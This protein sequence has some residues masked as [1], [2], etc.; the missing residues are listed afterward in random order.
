MPVALQATL[1]EEPLMGNLHLLLPLRVHVIWT[2][3]A[4]GLHRVRPPRR[5]CTASPACG[6]ASASWRKGN[7]GELVKHQRH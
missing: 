1:S 6:G 2:L 3:S 7:V 4:V 5:A